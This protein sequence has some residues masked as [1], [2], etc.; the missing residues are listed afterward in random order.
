MEVGLDKP[1]RL[2]IR[3]LF[4]SA[5]DLS[6]S[7]NITTNTETAMLFS[8]DWSWSR[9]RGGRAGWRWGRYW[10]NANV[11]VQS[12]TDI[13]AEIQIAVTEVIQLGH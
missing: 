10:A 12:D 1:A 8:W 13:I 5:S 2:I 3:L 6:K 11:A 4:R 9:R 7:T